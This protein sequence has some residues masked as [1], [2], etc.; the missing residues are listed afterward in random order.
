K[1]NLS[2]AKLSSEKE[3]FKIQNKNNDESETFII[4]S[5]Y[6]SSKGAEKLISLSNYNRYERNMPDSIDITDENHKTAKFVALLF[7]IIFIFYG[8]ISNTLMAAV[9]FCKEQSK[10]YSREF[11][12]ITSQLIISDLTTF[13]PQIVVV[14]PEILTARNNSYDTIYL[15]SYNNIE[16][17]RL[18]LV[19][20]PLKCAIFNS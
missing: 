15:L 14:L 12:L 3:Q 9:L 4:C 5:F 6:D 13:I 16:T 10:H 8:I 11:I 20:L 2:H 1:I 18:S 17:M 19:K 7:F